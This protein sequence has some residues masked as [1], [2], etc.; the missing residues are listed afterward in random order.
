MMHHVTLSVFSKLFFD[1]FDFYK[2]P[3]PMYF[4]T[5]T[6][7]ALIQGYELHIIEMGF[8][9]S[10]FRSANPIILIHSIYATNLNCNRPETRY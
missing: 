1:S 5:S 6:Y 7:L 3:A 2:I 10:S 9:H 4:H 8:L